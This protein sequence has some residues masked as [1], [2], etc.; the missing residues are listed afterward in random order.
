MTG[1]M[2]ISGDWNYA[3]KFGSV[4]WGP[5]VDKEW[6]KQVIKNKTCLVGFNTF[7]TIKEFKGL[8]NAPTKWYVPAYEPLYGFNKVCR[9][10]P[11][12]FDLDYL[13]IDYNLGGLETWKKY[14]PN[15]LIIHKV[16]SVLLGDTGHKLPQEF[17]HQYVLES[18][19]E[20]EFYTELIYV[21]K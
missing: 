20:L 18:M 5:A 1:L 21:K 10:H 13:K 4:E 15:K 2:L 11:L 14:P 8:M 17:L 19:E 16:D 12:E 9:L 7:E 6:L 3:D